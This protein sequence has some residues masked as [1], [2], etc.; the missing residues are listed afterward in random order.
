MNNAKFIKTMDAE[1]AKKLREL[2]C[3]ELN[4]QN[5]FFVFVNPMKMNF[6]IDS[7]KVSYT[8]NLTF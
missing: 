4:S 2:G 6:S 3:I 8:N 5:K 7:S 1:V